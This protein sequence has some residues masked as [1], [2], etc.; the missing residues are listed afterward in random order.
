MD[1]SFGLPFVFKK[2]GASVIGLILQRVFGAT[3]SG[4]SV[5]LPLWNFFPIKIYVCFEVDPS[6]FVRTLFAY[7]PHWFTSSNNETVHQ[8]FYTCFRD[9]AV[10]WSSILLICE[11][12]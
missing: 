12:K 5:F 7:N 4:H 10:I 8:S 9:F 3:F 11:Q 2:D 1:I 6:S